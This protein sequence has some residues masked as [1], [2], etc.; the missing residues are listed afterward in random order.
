MEDYILSAESMF[1]HQ[2]RDYRGVLSQVYL[3]LQLSLM[4]KAGDA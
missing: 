3:A 1:E 4:T 2:G